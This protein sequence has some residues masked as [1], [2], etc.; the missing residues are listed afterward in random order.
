LYPLFEALQKN[1][2]KWSA[3]EM[4]LDGFNER[5]ILATSMVAFWNTGMEAVG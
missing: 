2:Y 3:D 5:T 1:L 4:T